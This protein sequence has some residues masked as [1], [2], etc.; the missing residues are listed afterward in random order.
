MIGESVKMTKMRGKCLY[1]CV[2]SVVSAPLWHRVFLMG[3][4][5]IVGRCIIFSVVVASAPLSHHVFLMG[6]LGVVGLYV[7][8]L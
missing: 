1:G 7:V 6:F 3:F 4:L 8:F 2:L 5:G